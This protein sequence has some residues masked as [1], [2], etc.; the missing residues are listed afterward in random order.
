MG[1]E[2][3]VRGWAF[4]ARLW[5]GKWSFSPVP[6]IRTISFGKASH[7]YVQSHHQT[8]GAIA[9]VQS[10]DRSGARFHRASQPRSGSNSCERKI[11]QRH[12]R[13]ARKGFH[14]RGQRR[15]AGGPSRRRSGGAAHFVGGRGADCRRANREFSRLTG[16]SSMLDPVLS[17]PNNEAAVVFFDGKLNL[18]QDFTSDG[19]LVEADLK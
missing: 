14:P 6:K 11:R 7:N 5:R 4:L 17:N 8:S 9:R 10:R 1:R 19:D 15:G 2:N 12:L 3:P 16:L 18:A 13:S